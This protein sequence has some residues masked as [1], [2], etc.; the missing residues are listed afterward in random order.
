MNTSLY[1]TGVF[2]TE[3]NIGTS[4]L[5]IFTAQESLETVSKTL[6]D[7]VLDIFVIQIMRYRFICQN[8]F[9]LT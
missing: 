3:S 5:S 7:N 8:R 6:K 2:L 1:C 4:V 9:F